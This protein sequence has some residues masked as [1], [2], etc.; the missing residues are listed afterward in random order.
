MKISRNFVDSSTNWKSLQI[1]WKSIYFY[2][3]YNIFSIMSASQS[4][5][6]Y[7]IKNTVY[8]EKW[9][10]SVWA[11][12]S[13]DVAQEMEI[14]YINIYLI[15]WDYTTPAPP[16]AHCN[17]HHIPG[18]GFVLVMN[19][20]KRYFHL[21]EARTRYDVTVFL[22]KSLYNPCVGGTIGCELIESPRSM[23]N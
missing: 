4:V 2:L 11:S 1:S 17:T 19:I 10:T 21:Y 18:P 8:D 9:L 16:P 23:K 3:Q 6:V 5:H 14:T 22:T 20:Q 15:Q 13:G 12:S 7:R